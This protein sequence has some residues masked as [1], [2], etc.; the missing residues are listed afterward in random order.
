M[1]L[2]KYIACLCEGTAEEV[3]INILLDND[4]LIFNRSQL[5]E[6][7]PL[8]C[9]DARTFETRYLRKGFSDQISIIRILDSRREKFNLSKAY[10]HKIDVINV[11]TAPEIEMLVILAENK[12]TA[13]K[14]KSSHMSPSEFCKQDLQYR[15]VKSRDFVQDY[16]Q[17]ADKLI[18]AIHE[19]KRVSNIPN[20]EYSLADLLK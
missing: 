13:Y 18:A 7:T 10:Q 9:R 15:H 12:Y 19:Y 5:I 2:S 11:I 16:F 6:E 14:A 4:K 20:G 3:I 1:E 8:R 17:D